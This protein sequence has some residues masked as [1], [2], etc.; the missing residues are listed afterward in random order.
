MLSPKTI[1][2]KSPWAKEFANVLESDA[3]H[4]AIYA[5]LLQMQMNSP[6]TTDPTLA[7]IYDQR[8]TGAKQFVMT[9]SR[10]CDPE[11]TGSQTKLSGNLNH[12]F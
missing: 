5:A 2:Q 11:S 3:H 8:M 7:G 10:L 9:L 1:F 4:Q 6:E 12:K